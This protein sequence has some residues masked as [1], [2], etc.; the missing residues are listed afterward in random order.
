MCFIIALSSSTFA[1]ESNNDFL[2]IDDISICERHGIVEGESV[3]LTAALT[4]ESASAS[5][6]TWYSSNPEVV[7]CTEK[8]LIK[9]VSPGGY[10]DIYCKAVFGSAIDKIRV[11]CAE[12]VNYTVR[13]DLNGYLN[14]IYSEPS[15]L[16]PLTLH[17]NIYAFFADILSPMFKYV[18]PGIVGTT[19]INGA[20][21]AMGKCEIRGKIGSYAY[22]LSIREKSKETAL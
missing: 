18:I 9:G 8:G 7:S 22:I 15:Q 17:I 3:Q 1:V 6:V 21:F 14:V 13:S 20:P 10:A 16:K 19:S 2:N 11:Y 5:L 4:P 12:K